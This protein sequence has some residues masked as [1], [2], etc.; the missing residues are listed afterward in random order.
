MHIPQ[1]VFKKRNTAQG[2]VGQKIAAEKGQAGDQNEK[3]DFEMSLPAFD[4]PV[5]KQFA[6]VWETCRQ[7]FQQQNA[8][9]IP[10][11][12]LKSLRYLIFKIVIT[13]Y[14]GKT[15]PGFQDSVLLSTSC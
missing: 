10:A 12:I 4:L 14:L 9:Q 3:L 7:R 15:E 2:A 13:Y 1:I 8:E 11:A 6:K 5:L